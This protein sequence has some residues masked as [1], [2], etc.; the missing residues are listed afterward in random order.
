MPHPATPRITEPDGM[1]PSGQLWLP[2]AGL[3]ACVRATVVRNTVGHVLTDA[4]RFNHF[5]A[6]PLC[7]LSWWFEG[8]SHNVLLT[9]DNRHAPLSAPRQPM[10]GRWVL[11]GPHTQPT[12][13]WCPGPVHA[14]MVLLMP[15]AFHQL[16]GLEPEALT[17]RIVDAEAV[18]PPDW[19]PMLH[20]VQAAPDDATRL[21]RLEAFLA[22]R[23]AACR[24]PLPL[25]AHRY[26][27]WATHLAQRAA[28]SG[29]GRSL[30]QWERRV[31]RWAGLPMREL[32]VL[33]RSEQAFFQAADA[34]VQ[35]DAVRWAEVAADTGYADQAHLCRV[36]RRIT[37]FSPEALRRGMAED[38]A[39]WPY[40]LW[41]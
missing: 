7:S 11:G 37:G 16:T 1:L 38:E 28:V 36:S 25:Q 39:F 12:C 32:Q 8:C 26:A 29:P 18:L 5:P 2:A 20:D 9:D 23:W 15:D 3:S 35:G 31:K 33:A 24:H 41:L 10:P 6:A 13:S 22:P 4:Q 34:H 40:R 19:L 21:A 30:R 27:D 17:N 14:M